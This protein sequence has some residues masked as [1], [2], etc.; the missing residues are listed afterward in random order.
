MM[1]DQELFYDDM[2]IS[3]HPCCPSWYVSHPLRRPKSRLLSTCPASPT[4]V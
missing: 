1:I 4:P 3:N 2:V